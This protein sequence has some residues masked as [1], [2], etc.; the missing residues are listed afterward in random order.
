[1]RLPKQTFDT[2]QGFLNHISYQAPLLL[3]LDDPVEF[4][5]E[6]EKRTRDE[7]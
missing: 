6:L 4:Y 5:H 7:I 2:Y 1:M 3:C